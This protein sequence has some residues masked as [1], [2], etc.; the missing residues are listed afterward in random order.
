MGD[1]LRPLGGPRSVTRDKILGLNA[2]RLYGLDPKAAKV[3]AAADRMAAMR[4]EYVASGRRPET[5]AALLA[6]VRHYAGTMWG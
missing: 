1:L 4:A 5:A 2:A 6:E 3:S